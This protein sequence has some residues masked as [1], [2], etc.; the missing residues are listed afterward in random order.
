MS[1][2]NGHQK[3]YNMK[4]WKYSIALLAMIF[5]TQA[6]TIHF[7]Y[8]EGYS[9]GDLGNHP[10]WQ[11]N[12][13]DGRANIVNSFEGIVLLEPNIA[14]TAST[15]DK[16]V[17]VI[18]PGDSATAAIEFTFSKT[19]PAGAGDLFNVGLNCT[20]KSAVTLRAALK[21]SKSNPGTYQLFIKDEKGTIYSG[22]P[23]LPEKLGLGKTDWDSDQLRMAFTLT[24]TKNDLA[25]EATVRLFNGTTQLSSL[26][27][28]INTSYKW[29]GKIALYG[30][31]SSSRSDNG[32]KTTHRKIRSFMISPGPESEEPAPP[33][34][35][36]FG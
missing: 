28:I 18:N 13:E 20:S 6:E 23:I 7:T 29:H 33:P 9:D 22:R 10:H 19:G 4:T 16:G 2:G 15:Y 17:S 32:T 30:S 24:R 35:H 25:W 12:S 8:K 26:S 11:S 27:T 21:H 1:S 31:F 36:T 5:E 14:W 34:I 3:A